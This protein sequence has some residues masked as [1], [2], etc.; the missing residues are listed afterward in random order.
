[1]QE[2]VNILLPIS[3]LATSFRFLFLFIF[4]MLIAAI[5]WRHH[6]IPHPLTVCG[7]VLGLLT[8]N[9]GGPGLPQST[10]GGLVGFGMMAILAGVYRRT[11]GSVGMG[12]GDIMMSAMAGTFLGPVVLFVALSTGALLAIF[13]TIIRLRGHCA[14]TTHV[15]FGAYL[16]IST[17][18]MALPAVRVSLANLGLS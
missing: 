11:R 2:F 14:P 6:V 4:L 16:A 7:I 10:A 12:G 3:P 9:A 17:G 5:D 8:A 18:A 1:M 15:P 13:C